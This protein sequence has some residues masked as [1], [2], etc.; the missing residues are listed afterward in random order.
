M[1]P[2]LRRKAVN[3]K[4][5]RYQPDVEI[6]IQT[7]LISFHSFMITDIHTQMLI[8]KNKVTRN[9]KNTKYTF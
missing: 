1:P 9:Y 6:S 7:I 3:G 2:I 4:Q 8:I 5:H